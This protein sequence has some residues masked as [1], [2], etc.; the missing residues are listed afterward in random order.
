MEEYF[1]LFTFTP[2]THQYFL[3]LDG[4]V[5]LGHGHPA[6]EKAIED[7]RKRGDCLAGPTERMVELAEVRSFLVHTVSLFFLFLLLIFSCCTMFHLHPARG[8]ALLRFRVG[9]LRVTLLVSFW[10]PLCPFAIGA[11]S[12]RTGATPLRS[13]SA[14]LVSHCMDRTPCST[15]TS[16]PLGEE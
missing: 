6:V 16:P 8:D 11:F 4:P 7:Q 13:P 15:G 1:I 10:F 5:L 14:W 12:P 9:T 3:V 2:H